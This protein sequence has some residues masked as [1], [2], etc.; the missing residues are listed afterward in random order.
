METLLLSLMYSLM[1]LGCLCTIFNLYQIVS[2]G[3]KGKKYTL[4]PVRFTV[5]FVM[6]IWTVVYITSIL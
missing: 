3:R 2:D 6:T 1:G 4:C 5:W